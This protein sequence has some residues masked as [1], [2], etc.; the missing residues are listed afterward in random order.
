MCENMLIWGET[1]FKQTNKQTNVVLI[2]DP[3]IKFLAFFE[4]KI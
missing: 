2:N 4:V 1:K 3:P